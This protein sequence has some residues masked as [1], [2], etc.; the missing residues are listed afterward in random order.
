MATYYG[1]YVQRTSGG[2]TRSWRARLDYSYTE[3]DTTFTVTF[4]CWLDLSGGS[5]TTIGVSSSNKATAALYIAG[6]NVKSTSLPTSGTKTVNAASDWQLQTYTATY[7]KTNVQQTKTCTMSVTIASGSAWRGTSTATLTGGIVI[8]ALAM[9]EGQMKINGN[10]ETGNFYIKDSG[11]W[12][13][14]KEAYVKMNGT[15]QKMS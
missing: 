9:A 6:A 10:W 11:S 8:P 12:H 2:S 13:E 4:A 15:W 5:G 14:A 7:Q 1:S 3:T